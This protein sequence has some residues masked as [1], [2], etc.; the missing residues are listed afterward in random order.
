M[1]EAI[2]LENLIVK[3]IKGLPADRLLEIA[4]YVFFVR[5]KTFQPEAFQQEMDSELLN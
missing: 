5:K 4:E 3:V 1:N 2:N